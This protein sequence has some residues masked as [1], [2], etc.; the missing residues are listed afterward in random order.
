MRPR[1][2]DMIG[3]R[4]LLRVFALSVVLTFALASAAL[5][6][7][8]TNRI[9]NSPDAALENITLNEG[10]TLTVAFRVTVQGNDDDGGCNIDSNEQ[11]T[12]AVSSSDGSVATVS[13]QILAF[14][15][16][17]QDQSLTVTALA[18]GTATITVAQAPEPGSNTTG[19]GK[20]DYDP[21][22]F[23]VTVNAPPTIS[24]IPDQITDEDVPTGEIPFTVGNAETT[25]SDLEVTGSSSNTTLVPNGD[26]A[27]AGTGANR[28]VK[29]TSVANLAGVATITVEVSA[30][31][32]TSSDSFVLTVSPVNDSPVASADTKSVAEDGSLAF[33]ASDLTAN[34]SKGPPNESGQTLAVDSVGD[35]VNGTVNLSGGN[36][37]FVPTPGYSGPAGFEYTVCDDGTTGGG[38]DPK[39][40][41]G[42]VNVTVDPINHDPTITTIANQAISEDASTGE[43]AFSVGDPDVP[44]DSITVTASS[45]MQAL[46]P[47]GNIV[48]GGSDADRTVKVTSAPNA[49]SGDDGDARITLEVQ[50]GDGGA[51]TSSFLL[52][53]RPVNDKPGFIKG[54]DPSVPEDAGRQEFPGWAADISPGPANESNQSVWFEVSNSNASRVSG[55]M[56]SEWPRL[57][58]NGTLTFTSANNTNGEATFGMKLMDD[59]GRSNGGENASDGQRFKV[60][61]R[62]ENDWPTIGLIKTGGAKNAREGETK[63]Y[64]YEAEDVDE[65]DPIAESCGS[66]GKRI[67]TP[68]RNSFEC[69]FPDGPGTSVVSVTAGALAVGDEVKVRIANVAPKIT[70]N[71]PSRAEKGQTETYKFSIVDPGDDAIGFAAGHPDCGEG[72]RLVAKNIGANGGSF[73][74]E[75]RRPATTTVALRVEISDRALSDEEI[76]RVVV[77]GDDGGGQNPLGEGRGCDIEGTNGND[78]L[79]GT[80]G[81]DLICGLGGN[82]VIHGGDGDD[83]IRGDGGNDRLYGEGGM[84][85]LYARDGLGGE[86]VDGG[87]G[88]NICYGRPGRQEGEVLLVPPANVHPARIGQLARAF[89]PAA[90]FS[91]GPS[92]GWPR[93]APGRRFPRAR[94]GTAW[95]SLGTCPGRRVWPGANGRSLSPPCPG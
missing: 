13:P 83:I 10:A 76:R 51:A 81:N 93:R 22:S 84:D 4:A 2:K 67:D 62:P 91:R 92:A 95:P 78:E 33:P 26:I 57:S 55:A 79:W 88:R 32:A 12:V 48:L 17:N 35:P 3:S 64:D 36:V 89:R 46:V 18:R 1:C 59:G 63:T 71:G 16:C 8:V 24:D 86:L 11:L 53:V 21:A 23:T 42:T 27:F 75:F 52:K 20:F 72:N 40:D 30:G 82:D 74:C 37:T 49:N 7:E 29:V 41:S 87:A 65:P 70:L 25:A 15:D 39:C 43:L 34:D 73:R 80:P 61:I 77:T 9:D 60:T 56:F 50:D 66:R 19:S 44:A 45:N 28:T 54:A 47:D 6:D 14:T 5:A 69:F 68:A 58:P 38:P 31:A 90:G 94:R 85:G